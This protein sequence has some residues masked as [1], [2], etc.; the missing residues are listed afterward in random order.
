MGQY[1]ILCCL[2]TRE[3]LPTGGIKLGEFLFDCSTGHMTDLLAVPVPP[4]RSSPR[5][6]SAATA[7]SPF[8]KLPAEIHDLVFEKL[9]IFDVVALSLT[10]GYLF[11][12]AERH[13]N[14]AY[15]SL[16]GQWAG[17]RLMCIG[18]YLE[19]GDEPSWFSDEDKR[20]LYPKNANGGDISTTY[21]VKLFSGLVYQMRN[22][23]E[24][25]NDPLL[26]KK[27]QW[28]N[29]LRE[30][31]CPPLK[32]F[33]PENQPWV[34]RNLTTKEFVHA[35]AIALKKEHIHGP[36][37]DFRGFG[38][39]VVSRICWSSDPSVSM[40]NTTRIHRGKW[41]G[42]RFDITTLA[43]HELDMKKDTWKDVSEEAK[44]ELHMI[45]YSEFSHETVEQF[46]TMLNNWNV[47]TVRRA[48]APL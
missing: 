24:R 25:M 12:I 18:D 32:T 4:K 19:V 15:M 41:T 48:E 45:W 3:H 36:D 37:I 2:D 20:L 27:E 16:L 22:H 5:F 30:I 44:K 8:L 23:L 28:V 29:R 11:N 1:W 40:K 9:G 26:A 10:N 34:L 46:E 21:S 14:A 47:K 35:E 38:E 42:H 31:I 43:R 17:K 33:Y 13:I 7:H 6:K 39:L